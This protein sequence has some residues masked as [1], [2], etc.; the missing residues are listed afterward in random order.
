[1]SEQTTQV[2]VLTPDVKEVVMYLKKMVM[3]IMVLAVLFAGAG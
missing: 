3:L 2:G 1:M